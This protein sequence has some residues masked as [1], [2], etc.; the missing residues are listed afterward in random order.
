MNSI[1]PYKPQARCVEVILEAF[2]T[3]HQPLGIMNLQLQH[4][5]NVPTSLHFPVRSHCCPHHHQLLSL[6]LTSFVSPPW[7]LHILT[8]SLPKYSLHWSKSILKYAVTS[9]PFSYDVAKGRNML[10]YEMFV[11]VF[12]K[13]K[14]WLDGF[15]PI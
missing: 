3:S 15:S 7:A 9:L 1:C 5:S 8:C 13:W 2:S 4:L 11:Y 10:T 12:C 6:P 14:K